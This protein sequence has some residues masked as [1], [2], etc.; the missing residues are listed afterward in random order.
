VKV[1]F[2]QDKFFFLSLCLPYVGNNVESYRGKHQR[3]QHC[4]L[5]LLLLIKNYFILNVVKNLVQEAILRTQEEMLVTF[6][7]FH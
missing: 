6:L 7:A 2:I 3:T 4:D 5:F 1:T